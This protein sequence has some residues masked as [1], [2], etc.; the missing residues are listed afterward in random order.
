MT[1]Q[2]WISEVHCCIGLNLNLFCGK[3][4]KEAHTIVK[5]WHFEGLDYGGHTF[6]ELQIKPNRWR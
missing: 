2:V 6:F 4:A 3:R 5:I 1:K